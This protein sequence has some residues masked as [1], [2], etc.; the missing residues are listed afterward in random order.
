MKSLSVASAPAKV[1]LFGEHFVV[2]DRPAIVMAINM[3][4]YVKCRPGDNR[5]IIVESKSMNLSGVFT[6]SGEY[7][8]IIGG[9]ESKERLLPIYI[10][11]KSILETAGEERGVRVEV[12][13]NIPVEAGLGS[14]AAVSVASA[15]AVSDLLDLNVS[16][17]DIFRAALEAERMV[18]KNPSGV[19]PAISTYGG[20]IVYRRS[21]GIRRLDVDAGLTLIIGD[22]GIKRVTGEMVLRVGDM[23]RRYPLVVER[24]MDSG[25]AIVDLGVEALRRGDLKTIGELMNINHALL[26]ALGLSNETIERLVY[27]A[28]RAGAFGAKITGAGGGG[29]I[30][31]LPPQDRVNDVVRAVEDAGGRAFITDLSLEGV[32]V[33]RQQS[34][35]A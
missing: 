25:E 34:N 4:A 30:I 15:A 22:T 20:V 17:E 23:R 2:Y 32:R 29:C 11:V 10:A 35:N 8:P 13:S 12:N 28:R 5:R 7:Q 27:A 19:D 1:I 31:A 3:R 33:E 21:E 16:R 26:C 14:S 24:I 6:I 18:H 9:F